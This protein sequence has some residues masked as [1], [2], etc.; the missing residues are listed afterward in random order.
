MLRLSLPVLAE[1]LLNMLVG[2][3]DTWL[4]GNLLV[5][6][7]YLAAMTL[8]AYLLWLLGSIV[9]V[10]SIGTT[11]LTARFVGAGSH[12]AASHALNQSLV[13]GVALGAT[14]VV[15]G[16]L[17]A[18]NLVYAVGL[19]ANAAP[20]AIRYIYILLPAIPVFMLEQ[21]AFAALRGAGDTV[22]GLAVMTVVNVINVVVSFGLVLGWGPL[23]ALGWSGVA[24]GTATAYVVGGAI[25]LVLLVRGRAGLRIEPRLL[26]PDW[27]MMRRL[28]RV[29]L[30]A[31]CD[32][33]AVNLCQ[34]WFLSIISH[35]G[36]LAAAAHG[37]A[38]RVEALA[39]LPGTAF[40]V[41]AATLAGQH[42]GARDERRAV[43]SVWMASL[44]GTM[45]MTCAGVVFYFAGKEL[46]GLFV[47]SAQ[48]EVAVGAAPLL[49]I[50]ALA[51]P[52]F[53]LLMVV[54]GA[55]RGAGDTRWPLLVTFV[56]YLGVRIPL[57]YW[58]AWET[59][60]IP[61]TQIQVQ[62][63][64]LG[65]RGAWFAMATDLTVRGV[66]IVGRFLH[67]GWKRIE[68]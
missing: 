13:L 36:N 34:L 6:E 47:S 5:G 16:F 51:M 62:G 40:Q 38:I 18:D 3:A 11:A 7:Q 14:L 29:G 19:E 60:L 59:F 32:S 64:G 10:V 20:L 23:P 55:L 39:Y 21:I 2:F 25:V 54:S 37:V 8:N 48:E 12:G 27:G 33:A 52:P 53:A 45:V 4:A 50:I 46:A 57:A 66:L 35:M 9:A 17:W 67:G 43:R 44:A 61:G 42:L 63:L 15:L 24:I 26:V 68:V 56:G 22:T 49:Q 58:L 41:A 28:L 1:Q 31:G 65:V 30:P